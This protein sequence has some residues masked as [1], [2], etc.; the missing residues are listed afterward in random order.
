MTQTCPKHDWR[1]AV[2]EH[3]DHLLDIETVAACM[4]LKPTTIRKKILRREIAVVKMGRAVRIPERELQR[5]FA[6][7]YRPVLDPTDN[8]RTS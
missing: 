4:L 1:I 3:I 8:M 6:E 5:I 7:G 2:W